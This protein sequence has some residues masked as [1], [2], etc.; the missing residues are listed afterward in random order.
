MNRKS[1][2]L[3][4]S[5]MFAALICVATIVIRVPSPMNGYV[6][7]GDCFVL[8][9]AWVLGPVYGFAAG[10]MGSAMADLISGYVAYIPATFLIKGL[11]ALAAA[12]VSKQIIKKA[13][14]HPS[15]GYVAGSLLGEIIMIAGYFLYAALIF[16][17]GLAAFLSVPGNIVQGLVGMT[18]A[19]V[20][21]NLLRQTGLFHQLHVYAEKGRQVRISS[22]NPHS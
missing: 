12:L 22:S 16:G 17:K 8:L 3:V 2:K 15:I 10:G 4:L 19:V 9:A 11:M 14:R 7:F 18:A 6:N 5:A 13:P 1:E 20:F 21:I